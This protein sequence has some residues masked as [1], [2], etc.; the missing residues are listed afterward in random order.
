[1][2]IVKHGNETKV[3]SLNLEKNKK[4]RHGAFCLRDGV[5]SVIAILPDTIQRCRRMTQ[6]IIVRCRGATLSRFAAM[7]P[8]TWSLDGNPSGR[9][10]L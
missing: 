6:I 3:T 7:L 8:S 5:N 2:R 4:C 10:L 9:Y 1:M